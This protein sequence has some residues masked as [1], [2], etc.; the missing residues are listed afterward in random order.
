MRTPQAGAF[1][2]ARTCVTRPGTT[3]CCRRPISIDAVLLFAAVTTFSLDGYLER[4]GW[5]GAA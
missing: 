5:D 2:R 3:R 4:I 1:S